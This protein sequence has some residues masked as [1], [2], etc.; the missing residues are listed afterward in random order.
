MT[1]EVLHLSNLMQ[2]VQNAT[3]SDV[4]VFEDEYVDSLNQR[5]ALIKD[6]VFDLENQLKKRGLY[7]CCH[8]ASEHEAVEVGA[9]DEV[10]TIC[11]ECGAE[12]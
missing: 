7:K 8:P 1:K 10:I 2:A 5:I 4:E 9:T 3:Q 12:V 6:A 11:H